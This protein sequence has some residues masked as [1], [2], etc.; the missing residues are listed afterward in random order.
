MLSV[1]AC[2]LCATKQ[3]AILDKH[4]ATLSKHFAKT[5][6]SHALQLDLPWT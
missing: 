3:F 5:S 1:A 4:S 2:H 6:L